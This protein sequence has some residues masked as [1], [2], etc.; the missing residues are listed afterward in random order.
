MRLMPLLMEEDLKEIM[1]RVMCGHGAVAL[2]SRR[3]RA[4]RMCLCM[5]RGAEREVWALAALEARAHNRRHA[6]LATGGLV[7]ATVA[8][9]EEQI[10]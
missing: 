2:D 3:A 8:L 4:A 10:N 6:A 1:R 5:T 7:H 9:N